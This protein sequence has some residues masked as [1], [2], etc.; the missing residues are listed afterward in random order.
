MGQLHEL[1][2]EKLNKLEDDAWN[3]RFTWSPAELTFGDVIES[4]G[5]IPL[6]PYVKRDDEE[7]DYIRYQTVFS[8][9]EG[10]V[11]A[12]TAGLHFTNE[13]INSLREKGIKMAE[14]TLH[15]GAGTFQPVRSSDLSEHEMHCEHYYISKEL[16]DNTA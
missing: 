16:I 8:K 3:I 5:H 12:P 10:S 7:I 2:A 9:N 15:T 14:L 6:P 11:A 1:T 13:V 4:A